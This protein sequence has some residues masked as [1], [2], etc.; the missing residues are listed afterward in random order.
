MATQVGHTI[1]RCGVIH[2]NLPLP[3]PS[4]PPFLPPDSFSLY[5]PS[6][7][8]SPYCWY[9]IALLPVHGRC[10]VV[11]SISRVLIELPLIDGSTLA[12][13]PFPSLPKSVGRT[14]LHPLPL[15]ERGPECHSNIED[16]NL[17]FKRVRS[18]QFVV[19]KHSGRTQCCCGGGSERV[20]ASA[21]S[22]LL[23]ANG[24]KKCFLITYDSKLL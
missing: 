9:T 1:A 15:P 23:E 7:V 13:P 19:V 12:P 16:C 11:S 24:N 2:H 8:L 3:S 6:P 21:R 4:F 5:E 14:P 20:C 17:S 22:C 18:S 10:M